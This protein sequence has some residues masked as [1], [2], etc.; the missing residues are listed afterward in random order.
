MSN[1]PV[2]VL[3]PPL[4][5][6]VPCGCHMPDSPPGG[7]RNLRMGSVARGAPA[8]E[9]YEYL[10]PVPQCPS[11]VWASSFLPNEARLEDRT[12][13]QHLS[14]HGVPML[15]E[16]AEQEARRKVKAWMLSVSPP[17]ELVVCRGGLP[18]PQ[19]LGPGVPWGVGT[20]CVPIKR[21]V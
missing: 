12:Q 11:Q 9:G 8:S 20:V 21:H 14:Q 7:S 13:R 5:G 2:C 15:L 6:T 4:L 16:Y 17:W 3:S 1:I 19:E 18:S 10:S